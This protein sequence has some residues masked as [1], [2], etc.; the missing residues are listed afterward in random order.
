MPS[1][2]PLDR[3][4]DATLMRHQ[5][6]RDKILVQKRFNLKNKQIIDFAV[7]LKYLFQTTYGSTYKISIQSP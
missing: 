5:Q 4:S 6:F 7:L 2:Y 1:P 3:N